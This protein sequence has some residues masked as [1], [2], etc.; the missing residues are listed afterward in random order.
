MKMLSP[1]SVAAILDCNR[2]QVYRLIRL[3][4]LDSVSF[5][6]K[7]TRI[8]ESSVAD[9]IAACQERGSRRDTGADGL[10]PEDEETLSNAVAVA[11]EIERERKRSAAP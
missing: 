4:H 5:G 6:R 1:K 9:Y 7:M 11:R 10:P 8:P 2:Q 3:G